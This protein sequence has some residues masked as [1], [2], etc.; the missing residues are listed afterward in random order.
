MPKKKLP[1]KKRKSKMTALDFDTA[2][3]YPFKRKKALWNI[4]WM[5]L[6]IIGWFVLIGYSVRIIKEFSKGK[7]KQLPVLKFKSDMKLGFFMFFKSLPFI[8]I[9]GIII[10]GLTAINPFLRFITLPFE[11][12][13]IPILFV[14]FFNKETISS[15]FE[16]KLIHVVIDN[17][18]DYAMVFLRGLA[19]GLTF[20]FLW[21][22]LIGI[23]AGAFTSYIF[24]ADFYR[25]HVK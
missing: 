9:Y 19:L 22:V 15:L 20:F 8:I 16:F 12:L 3:R 13:L 14:N 1:A 21:I 25:R 10:G 23:P 2:F 11:I 5:F 6:P 4:L 7:F 18:G 24:V 17:L